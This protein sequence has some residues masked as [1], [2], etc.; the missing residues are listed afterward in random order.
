[1]TTRDWIE[2]NINTRPGYDRH[3]SSVCQD[4]NGDFYSYGSH[5]PLLVNFKGKWVLNDGGYS[6]TTSK[7]IS[8]CYGLYDFRIPFLRMPQGYG[9]VYHWPEREEEQKEY[10]VLSLQNQISELTG[11]IL[12][13]KR[14]DTWIYRN[15]TERRAKKFHLK[16]NY[17]TGLERYGKNTAG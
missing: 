12:K 16:K 7:H 15:L 17:Q 9:S 5:Y 11:E 13:K 14:T 1:M 8:W 2:K 10:L 3:C 6:V 4:S